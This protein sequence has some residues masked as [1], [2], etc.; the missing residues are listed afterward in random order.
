MQKH[1]LLDSQVLFL[2]KTT[3]TYTRSSHGSCRWFQQPGRTKP[4]VINTIQPAWH[5]N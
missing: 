1:L 5:I 3:P 2:L 4:P